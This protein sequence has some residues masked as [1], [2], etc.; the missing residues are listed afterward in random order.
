MSKHIAIMDV[1][2]HVRA[3]GR[4]PDALRYDISPRSDS[5]SL[6]LLVWRLRTMTRPRLAAVLLALLPLGCSFLADSE[7]RLKGPVGPAV[8]RESIADHDQESYRADVR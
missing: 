1:C 4:T 7:S 5:A 3:L 8:S 2:W 6:I